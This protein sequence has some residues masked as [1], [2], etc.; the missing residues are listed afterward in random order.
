MT[1]MTIAQMRDRAVL[2]LA[3]RKTATPTEQDIQDARRI[4]NSFYRLCGL[5]E[6]LLYLENDERTHDK[7]YTLE[8]AAKR[9]RWFDRLNAIF[10]SEYNACLVYFGYCPT[11]CANG[12]T[13]DL[14]LRHF[15]N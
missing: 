4:M 11:I 3:E 8:K 7:P 14:Y 5:D 10:K 12:T 1:R 15:Y 13:Q 6:Q 9:E 2:Q